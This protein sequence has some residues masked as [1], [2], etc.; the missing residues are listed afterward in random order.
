MIN[1]IIADDE[2]HARERLR[3]L[4]HTFDLFD[5]VAEAHDANEALQSIITLEPLVA[6]L[7]INMPGISVFQT[8]PSLKKPPLIVFQTA[9]S[10]HAADAYAIDALDYLLKPIRLERLGKTVIKIQNRISAKPDRQELTAGFPGNP[11]TQISVGM[12]GKTRIIDTEDIIRISMENEFCYLYS[13]CERLITDKYLTYYEEKLTGC[14]F[15]RVSRT[16]IINLNHIAAIHKVFQGMYTIEL[17]NGM[18]VE[19]SRRRAQELKKIIDF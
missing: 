3:D 4:L 8:I 16:D 5:I 1:V 10:Q 18:Q 13:V 6:F 11:V 17:K 15:F 19:M 2:A 12:S 7:D 14:R 9:Y